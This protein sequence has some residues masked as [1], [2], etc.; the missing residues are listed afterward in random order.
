VALPAGQVLQALLSGRLPDGR[1]FDPYATALVEGRAAPACHPPDPNAKVTLTRLRP[2]RVELRTRSARG[3]VLVLAD[4][5]YPGWRVR[6][7]GRPAALLRADYL[8]RGV[9]VPA[10]EHHVEFVFRPASFYAGL[11]VSLAALLLTLALPL[12]PLLRRRLAG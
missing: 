6:V 1:P 5:W 10:G 3:A 11:G 12:R 4:A 2:D 7:D 9:A 8:L